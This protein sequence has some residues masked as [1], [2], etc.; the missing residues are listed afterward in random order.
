ME[1]EKYEPQLDID[2]FIRR[3]N[4]LDDMKKSV[5]RLMDDAEINDTL[6]IAKAFPHTDGSGRLDIA[7]HGCTCGA[8]HIIRGLA[9]HYGLSLMQL[10]L[11]E[12]MEKLKSNDDDDR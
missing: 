11:E 1:K 5:Q 6:V 12:I 4:S 8:R 3:S 9:Q 7:T 2:E 10:A